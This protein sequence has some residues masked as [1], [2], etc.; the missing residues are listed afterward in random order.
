[1]YRCGQSPK[2][3]PPRP[4]LSGLTPLAILH[5]YVDCV[6]L[7]V[8][9]S[10]TQVLLDCS[11]SGT[12]ELSVILQELNK[13]PGN[14]MFSGLILTD[15]PGFDRDIFKINGNGI[16]PLLAMRFGYLQ[17]PDFGSSKNDPFV[18]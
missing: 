14:L 5:G 13:L 16:F 17:F 4:A 15:L 11:I 8:L 2:V 18:S 6:G 1:M 10:V 7:I 9:S 12:P 3:S